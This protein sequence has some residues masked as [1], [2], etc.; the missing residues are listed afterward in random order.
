MPDLARIPVEVGEV[1]RERE[2]SSRV[3]FTS[4]DALVEGVRANNPVAVAELYDRFAPVVGRVLTRIL[5]PDGVARLTPYSKGADDDN[6]N[7]CEVFRAEWRFEEPCSSQMRVRGL[8]L[9]QW[10][11]SSRV[12]TPRR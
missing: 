10:W 6:R 1:P 12:A 5:G 11:H 4:D 7:G 8:R 3:S 9:A 2:A